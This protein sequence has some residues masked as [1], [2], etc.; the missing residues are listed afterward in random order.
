MKCVVLLFPGYAQGWA[1]PRCGSLCEA[2]RLECCTSTGT[3]RACVTWLASFPGP[4]PA[5]RR[6]HLGTRLWRDGGSGLCGVDQCCRLASTNFYYALLASREGH[7]ALWASN[8]PFV[9]WSKN[10]LCPLPPLWLLLATTWNTWLGKASQGF[11]MLWILLFTHLKF[12]G[13]S[14]GVDVSSLPRPRG[15][16]TGSQTEYNLKMGWCCTIAFF[17]M[18]EL[19]PGLQLQL[20]TELYH[21]Q[22]KLTFTYACTSGVQRI[23]C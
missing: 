3:S 15:G 11:W 2:R 12:L 21:Q 19:C 1:S 9:D 18:F 5:F 16:L 6:L 20:C 8:A 4:C 10:K 13:E 23:V 7:C 14:I 17:I 22:T